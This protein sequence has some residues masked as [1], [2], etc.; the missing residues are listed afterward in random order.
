MLKLNKKEELEH[1][2]SYFQFYNL[3]IIRTWPQ[4]DKG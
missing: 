2:F 3:Q 4:I 1:I